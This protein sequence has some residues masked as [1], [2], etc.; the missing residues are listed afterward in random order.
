LIKTKMAM[1]RG[2]ARKKRS[3]WIYA[4]ITGHRARSV[5]PYRK[6]KKTTTGHRGFHVETKGC[7]SLRV[8]HA[9]LAVARFVGRKR[10]RV[11]RENSTE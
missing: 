1:A 2:R 6:G 9:L 5:L 3:R 10:M 8:A 4:I 11:I 7:T